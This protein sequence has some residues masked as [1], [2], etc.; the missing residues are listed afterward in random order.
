MPEPQWVDLGAIEEFRAVPLRQVRVGRVALAVSCV[1]GELGVISGVCNHIGGPLG[2]GTLDGDYVTCAWHYWK[3]HRVTGVGEP[4][5]EDDRVPSHAW[6]EE[7]GRLLVDLTPRTLR[8]KKPHA[9]HPLARPVVRAEGPMR[10]LGLSTTS[11]DEAHPRFSGSDHLLG[12]AVAH[13]RAQ[14]AEAKIIKLHELKFRE[15]EG[16]YSKSARACTWPCSITQLDPND[17][18]ER[19]YEALVHWADVLLVATPIRWGAASSLY[20]KL[21]ERLNCVQNEITNHNRV[22]IRDRVAAFVIV[23]GQDNVQAVAGHMLGFFSE[24]GFQFPAFPFIAHSRGWTAEDMEQNVADVRGSVELAMAARELTERALDLSARLRH[25]HDEPS[26]TLRRA[27]RK[28]GGDMLPV[29]EGP[30]RPR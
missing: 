19:V 10:V 21:A 2:E 23:G 1:D 20:H 5:F 22:L 27:G 9:P 29:R 26:W 8:H 7:G 16:F 30:A 15:C 13:A 28:A 11:M 17:Q 3:F 25:R 4:G 18:L 24:L 6:R 12:I 14:G